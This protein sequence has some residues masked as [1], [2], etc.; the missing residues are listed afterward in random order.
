LRDEHEDGSVAVGKRPGGDRDSFVVEASAR[1]RRNSRRDG[2]GR[3]LG[4]T[5]DARKRRSGKAD[6]VPRFL[7]GVQLI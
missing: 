1:L 5:R 4:V 6:I 7:V 2:A 3:R